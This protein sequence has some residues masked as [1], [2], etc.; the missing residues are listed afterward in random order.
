MG[1]PVAAPPLLVSVR[2][3]DVLEPSPREPNEWLVGVTIREPGSW[4]MPI[5]WTVLVPPGVAL[6]VSIV[7]RAPA[8]RGLKRTVTAQAAAAASPA[9]VQ[10]LAEMV[11]LVL[12]ARLALT[13]PLMAPP[14]LSTVKS[15]V[16]LWPLTTTGPKLVLPGVTSSVATLSP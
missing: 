4:P 5:S 8:L 1:A 15:T 14:V 2:V 10:V 3:V 9:P 7:L 6:T 16:A 13:M 12:S 11:K